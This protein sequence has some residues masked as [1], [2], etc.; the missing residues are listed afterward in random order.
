MNIL[1]YTNT[2]VFLKNFLICY[3]HLLSSKGCWE[4]EVISI[5]I[6]GMRRWYREVIIILWLN[7]SY[8][9]WS[10]TEEMSWIWSTVLELPQVSS[11]GLGRGKCS[12]Y[13]KDILGHRTWNPT[14][15]LGEEGRVEN[16]KVNGAWG[17]VE[18]IAEWEW[19]HL[20]N[21]QCWVHM[22]KVPAGK[23]KGKNG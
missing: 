3:L 19:G 1:P 12:H 21:K 16:L 11:E 6:L 20:K 8:V 9:T 5:P 13:N 10:E 7:D 4:V 2:F 23:V 15:L 14:I 18:R 17:Q 22:G